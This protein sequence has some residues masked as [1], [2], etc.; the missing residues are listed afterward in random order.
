MRKAIKKKREDVEKLKE[1]LKRYK[2]FGIIDLRG[3]PSR[4]FQSIKKMLRDIAQVRVVKRVVIRYT[5]EELGGKYKDLLKYT[6]NIIP[7]IVLSNVDSFQLMAK[8][9]NNLSPAPAKPGQLAPEDITIKAGPTPF[10]PGPVLSEFSR[11]GVKARVVQGKIA[12]LSDTVVAKKEQEISAPVASMLLK[13]GIEPMKVGLNLVVTY[14]DGKIYQGDILKID[15]DEFKQEL[16][17][18]YNHA[19]NLA[20]H[21]GFIIKETVEPMI[22]KA[23]VSA[24][25]LALE[26]NILSEDTVKEIFS[27][28]QVQAV[29]LKSTIKE[30]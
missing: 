18:A 16:T 9:Q 28:A 5:L 6:E 10:A 24:K 22:Q 20:F 13:L 19:F 7:A 2:V 29:S 11:I 15:E 23:V 1:E 3:L 21:S 14:E 8:I 25:A 27:K 4:Q 17:N 30:E 12:V 26:A